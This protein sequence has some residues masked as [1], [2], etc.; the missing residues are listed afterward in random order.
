MH[1][2]LFVHIKSALHQ[3]PVYSNGVLNLSLAKRRPA[4]VAWADLWLASERFNSQLKLT[5]CWCNALLACYQSIDNSLCFSVQPELTVVCRFRAD[6]K[7]VYCCCTLAERHWWQDDLLVPTC[8]L[9]KQTGPVSRVAIRQWGRR[10][11]WGVRWPYSRFAD[12][13]LGVQ[14]C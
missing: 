10:M 9:A 7:L 1:F 4:H 2:T 14:R 5:G 6:G 3:Q 12:T 13:N 11:V 8:S